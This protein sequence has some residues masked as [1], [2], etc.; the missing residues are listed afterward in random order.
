MWQ[1][2]AHVSSVTSSGLRSFVTNCRRRRSPLTARWPESD[3]RQLLSIARHSSTRGS[4]PNAPRDLMQSATHPSTRCS[5]V[6]PIHS[7]R[8]RVDDAFPS[9]GEG[10][11][12]ARCTNLGGNSSG[13]QPDVLFPSISSNSRAGTS[14]PRKMSWRVWRSPRWGDGASPLSSPS[15]PPSG[16]LSPAPA[17][18][19]KKCLLIIPSSVVRPLT[20]TSF[21]GSP[22]VWDRPRSSGHQSM[23]TSLCIRSG[24]W[25]APPTP[26][27]PPLAG[28]RLTAGTLRLVDAASGT[29]PPAS[30]SESFTRLS[31]AFVLRS[32]CGPDTNRSSVLTRSTKCSVRSESGRPPP[33]SSAP[34]AS[35]HC[36]TCPSS[37]PYPWSDMVRSPSSPAVPSTTRIDLH[38]LRRVPVW[39]FLA[40]EP[41]PPPPSPKP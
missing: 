7:C 8:R 11:T 24:D 33:P 27:P 14:M 32:S 34:A 22:S 39:F 10:G 20:L 5:N 26:P 2:V 41:A 40:G 30:M 18:E 1:T 35:R 38:P 12:V 23:R 16:P 29:I 13:A 6:V 4:L 37:I 28:L 3:R 31:S 15:P 25:R 36:R 17:A 21:L 19:G 9:S